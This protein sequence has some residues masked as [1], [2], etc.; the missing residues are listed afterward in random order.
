[1]L[2]LMGGI[3]FG[4]WN[5]SLSRRC[6]SIKGTGTIV[7]FNIYIVSPL[8]SFAADTCDPRN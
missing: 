6:V 1:V 8:K 2:Q 3:L 7:E 4:I 5:W